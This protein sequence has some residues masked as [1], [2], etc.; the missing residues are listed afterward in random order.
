MYAEAVDIIDKA[1]ADAGKKGDGGERGSFVHRLRLLMVRRRACAVSNH[2]AKV[3]LIL[4]DVRKS[5]LLTMRYARYT[6]TAVFGQ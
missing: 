5:V 6:L 2:E 3:S 4:R 1:R